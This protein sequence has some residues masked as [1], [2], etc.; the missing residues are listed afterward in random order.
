MYI[1][2]NPGARYAKVLVEATH[3]VAYKLAQTMKQSTRKSPA[4]N[5][6]NSGNNDTML[7]KY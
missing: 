1:D 4:I 3:L 6:Q 5:I 7:D 2:T